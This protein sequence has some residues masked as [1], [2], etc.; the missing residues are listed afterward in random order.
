MPTTAP[1]LNGIRF[2]DFA[3]NSRI[4]SLT[5]DLGRLLP[6]VLAPPLVNV[7]TIGGLAP[8]DLALEARDDCSFP[9]PFERPLDL[10]VAPGTGAPDLVGLG[11]IPPRM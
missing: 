1:P 3:S 4:V 10:E 9:L 2:R 8:C 11:L 5:R 6:V 7:G